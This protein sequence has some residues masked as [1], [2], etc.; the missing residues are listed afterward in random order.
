MCN[1]MTSLVGF[2]FAFLLGTFLHFIIDRSKSYFR[3]FNLPR[4]SL[5]AQI[6]CKFVVSIP[7]DSEVECFSLEG[8][9]LV[10]Y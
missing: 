3:L 8:S 7:V 9:K 10:V 2:I 6:S 4:F 5:A 1:F